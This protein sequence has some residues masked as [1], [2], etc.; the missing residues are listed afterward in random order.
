MSCC[1]PDEC[2]RLLRV[3]RNLSTENG[4]MREQRFCSSHEPEFRNKV[5]NSFLL[6]KGI[7]DGKE[8]MWHEIVLHIFATYF[9]VRVGATNFHLSGT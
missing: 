1:S 5:L 2:D 4:L 8:E 3:V 9:K 6:M 7:K